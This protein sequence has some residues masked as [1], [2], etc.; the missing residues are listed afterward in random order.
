MNFKQMDYFLMIAEEGSFSK[1]AQRLFIS[2]QSL[3]EAISNME[4]EYGVQFFQRKRPLV[5]TPAGVALQRSALKIMKEKKQLEHFFQ[6]ITQEQGGIFKFG[7]SIQHSRYFLSHLIPL[8]KKDFPNVEVRLMQDHQYRLNQLLVHGDIDLIIG[9]DSFDS[10]NI[11][12][13]TIGTD[14]IYLIVPH[15]IMEARFHRELPQAVKRLSNQG[16]LQD[17]ASSP[18]LLT[19]GTCKVRKAFNSLCEQFDIHP[20]VAVEAQDAGTLLQFALDGMGIAVVSQFLLL[21]FKKEILERNCVCAFPLFSRKMMAGYHSD[22]DHLPPFVHSFIN[23]LQG[24]CESGR[25]DTEEL[26]C[27]LQKIP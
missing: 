13:T 1:A 8:F 11:H 2:Q 6:G 4:K 18:F 24:L 27:Q 22:Y 21:N 14:I 15:T 23:D 5:L 16:S 9:F 17:F 7:T 10:P 3:S 25:S 19:G 20:T 26:I 12:S